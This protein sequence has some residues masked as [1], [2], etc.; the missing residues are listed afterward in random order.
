MIDHHQNEKRKARVCHFSNCLWIN[1]DPQPD[2]LPFQGEREDAAR[3]GVHA[4]ERQGAG[5][6][7]EGLAH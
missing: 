1:A 5:L 2:P 7:S 6:P 4:P 3:Q